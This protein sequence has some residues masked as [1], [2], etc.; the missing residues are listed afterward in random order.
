VRAD[1]CLVLALNTNSLLLAAHEGE[2]LLIT[3]Y[4]RQLLR[5]RP[6]DIGRRP[7]CTYT[8]TSS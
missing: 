6:E 3:F 7:T 4:M 2:A 8:E 5:F 1:T